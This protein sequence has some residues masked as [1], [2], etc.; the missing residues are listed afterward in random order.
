MYQIDHRLSCW[1]S[2]VK[3][4]GR[5]KGY[6]T[7][8]GQMPPRAAIQRVLAAQCDQCVFIAKKEKADYILTFAN[9]PNGYEWSVIEGG[10]CL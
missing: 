5:F 4:R 10:R 9:A 6:S 2:G 1:N 3:S 8:E 7:T